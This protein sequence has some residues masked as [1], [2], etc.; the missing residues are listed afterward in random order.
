M[1]NKLDILAV[2]IH[3]D[4]VELG[5]SG[6]LM[7]ELSLGKKCGILHLS[8]GEMGTRGTAE[9]RIKE[10]RAAAKLMGVTI[11]EQLDLS[12]CNFTNDADSRLKIIRVIRQYQPQIVLCG[13]LSDRHPDHGRSGKMVAE[14]CFYSGL[15]KI[16]TEWEGKNQMAFRPK[17]VY[18][19]AQD[20]V[21]VPHFVVDISAYMQKKL[22]VIQCYSSQFY[23]A[24]SKETETPI[25]GKDFLQ[26]VE[27][28][29]KVYGREI[30]VEFGEAFVSERPLGVNT[31]SLL[32]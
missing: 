20:R 15:A 8:K 6:T 29:A 19:Y 5:C 13:A 17:A 1:Q 22:E 9:L 24:A 21:V 12:D 11:L 4:D 2:G 3:P 27:G 25:S 30:G 28:K 32:S 26:L 10:S 23:N 7:R 16:I 18:H 31:L 14:S